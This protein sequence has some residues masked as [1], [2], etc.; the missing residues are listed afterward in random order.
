MYELFGCSCCLPKL[1]ICDT[2]RKE[3]DFFN[4]ILSHFSQCQNWSS[5]LNPTLH[6]KKKAK[7]IENSF[8]F[9]VEFNTIIC[10]F[11]NSLYLN[12]FKVV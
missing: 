1:A 12:N 6:I 3:I 10:Y 2:F 9:Y 4:E 8:S 7:L 5:H 11:I